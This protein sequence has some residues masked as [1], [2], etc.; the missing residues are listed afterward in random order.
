MTI[1]EL[2][3]LAERID[4][5]NRQLTADIAAMKQ[6]C[7]S[8]E[9]REALIVNAEKY[10]QEIIEALS[11]IPEDVSEYLSYRFSQGGNDDCYRYE[12]FLDS[13]NGCILFVRKDGVWHAEWVKQEP[14]TANLTNFIATCR[15]TEGMVLDDVADLLKRVNDLK[16]NEA[17]GIL[18]N[19][20]CIIKA[21]SDQEEKI[22]E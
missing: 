7:D 10:Q 11:C 9:T 8:K 4:R 21:A 16:L 20:T 19:T 18:Q 22:D 12:R 3:E 17:K 15:N 13:L 2:K 5:N 14:T 6:S 1:K